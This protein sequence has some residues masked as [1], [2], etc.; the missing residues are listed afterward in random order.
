MNLAALRQYLRD[1]SENMTQEQID[2]VLDDMNKIIELLEILEQNWTYKNM[3]TL[4]E[5][6]S[7]DALLKDS[8]KAI[9]EAEKGQPEI[10]LYQGGELPGGPGTGE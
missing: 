3:E 1:N 8:K 6:Q 7:L 5:L 4:I 2:K 9:A 10:L